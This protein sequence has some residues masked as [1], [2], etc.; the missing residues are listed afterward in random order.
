MAEPGLKIEE[1]FKKVRIAVREKTKG[2]QTPW[3]ST[4][5]T[6]DFYPVGEKAS[7]APVQAEPSLPSGRRTEPRAYCVPLLAIQGLSHQVAFSPDGRTVLSGSKDNTLKLWDA[8]SGRELHSFPGHSGAVWSVAISP[9][10]RTALSGSDDKTLRLWDI[11]EWTQPRE[12]R[13]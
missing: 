10:G 8:A 9:D 2:E 11:S 13:R 7:A 6:G 1:V 3:E 5:L 12:A 4:S